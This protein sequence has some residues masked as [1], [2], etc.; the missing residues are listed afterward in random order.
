M[1]DPIMVDLTK[2]QKHKL[3]A[4]IDHYVSICCNYS[5]VIQLHNIT[6][7]MYEIFVCR[8]FAA[9]PSA[10]AFQL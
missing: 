3:P 8:L 10:A 9:C 4:N 7:H 5:V 1:E 2:N 6:I